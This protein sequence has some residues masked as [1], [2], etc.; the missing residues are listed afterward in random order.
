MR[1][2]ACLAA[3]AALMALAC[4]APKPPLLVVGEVRARRVFLPERFGW[5]SSAGPSA[6]LPS[7]LALGGSA[8]GRLLL[9]FEFPELA[10]P[11]RLRRADLLLDTSGVPGDSVEVELSRAE[12]ARGL[13]QWSEQPR[14]LYPRLRARLG[15]QGTPLHLDVTELGRTNAPG[16]PLRILLR[17]EPSAGAPVLVETGAAGGA[18]PRLEAYWD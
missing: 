14:A 18:A 4:G 16:Q 11:E 9:Y 5:F 6:A 13:E 2:P 10:Q 15:S 1:A 7:A 12:A 17:A 8:S 3:L